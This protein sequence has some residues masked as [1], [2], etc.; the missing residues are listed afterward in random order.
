MKTVLGFLGLVTMGTFLLAGTSGC[1]VACAEDEEKKGTTCVAKSLTKFNGQPGQDSATWTAGGDITVDGVFGNIEVIADS[2]DNTVSVTFTPFS[3]RGHD[4]EADAIR[5]MEEAL[6]TEAVESGGGVLVR[7][8]REGTHGSSLGAQMVVH[9]PSSFDAKLIVINRGE[10]NVSSDL[11]FDVKLGSV[12]AAKALDVSTGSDLGACNIYGAPSV[13]QSD[14]HCGEHVWLRDVSD[15]VNVSTK[16]GAVIDEAIFIDFASISAG[17][18]GT[19][20]SED[21]DINLVL[22]AGNVFSIQAQ[23]SEGGVVEVVN[24][25]AECGVEVAAE[26]SKTLS[27]GAGGPNYVVTAGVDSLGE[28]NVKLEF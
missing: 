21:G 8:W 6:K 27:C 12:G 20:T 3:Y 1:E 4:Q 22:P 28:S 19:I 23:S 26:T 9:I 18:G 13:T 2:P 5:D 15:S 10:G 24:N 14:V 25:P 11:D 16:F 17:S 7:S